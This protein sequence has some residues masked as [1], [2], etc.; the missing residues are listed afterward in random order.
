MQFSKQLCVILL[1]SFL[2]EALNRVLPFTIPAGVYG[3]CLLLLALWRGWVKL[4]AVKE[5]GEFLL[6]I[7]P[8]IFVPPGVGLITVWSG[9]QGVLLPICGIV[10]VSTVL[11]MLSSAWVTQGMLRLLGKNHPAEHASREGGQ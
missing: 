9:L 3:F 6:K 7:L 8:L 2:G 11:V 4:S 1:F 10:L 5:T